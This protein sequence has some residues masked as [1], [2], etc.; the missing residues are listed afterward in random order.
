[1][2]R[3]GIVEQA[4]DIREMLADIRQKLHADADELG[5][6]P[7]ELDAAFSVSHLLS[8]NFTFAPIG[9]KPSRRAVLIL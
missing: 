9:A 3:D 2:Y 7:D 5:M 6:S 1:M 4:E 8:G